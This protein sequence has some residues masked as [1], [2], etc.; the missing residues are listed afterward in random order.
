MYWPG[1]KIKEGGNWREKKVR[2]MN[3]VYGE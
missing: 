2:E 1:E 3:V